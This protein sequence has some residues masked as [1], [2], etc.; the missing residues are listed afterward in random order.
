MGKLLVLELICLVSSVGFAWGDEEGGL[1]RPSELE[2]FVDE[3]PD[4]PRIKAFDIVDASPVPISLHIGMFH[5]KWVTSLSL[6]LQLITN[7][8]KNRL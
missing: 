2:K 3:I 4:I 6:P 7:F 8:L 5:K 1:I